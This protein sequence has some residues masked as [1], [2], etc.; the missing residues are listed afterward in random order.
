MANWLEEKVIV[1]GAVFVIIRAWIQAT[2]LMLIQTHVFMDPPVASDTVHAFHGC[3]CVCVR[4]CVCVC[5]CVCVRVCVC[6]Y[7]FP[8]SKFSGR[9]GGLSARWPAQLHSVN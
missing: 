4:A 6:V 5:V 2:C 1:F 7:A 3:V 8:I 9:A